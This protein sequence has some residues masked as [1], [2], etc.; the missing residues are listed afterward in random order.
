MERRERRKTER[1]LRQS[2]TEPCVTITTPNKATRR[3][4]FS[5]SDTWKRLL[6]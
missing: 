1:H 4:E 2:P 5:I 3:C 6:M